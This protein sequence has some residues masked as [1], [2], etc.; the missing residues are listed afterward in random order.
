MNVADAASKATL[1]IV[2]D[3]PLN[4]KLL[5]FMLEEAQYDT[6]VAQSG[7]EALELLEEHEPDLALLDVMMPDIDGF[8]LCRRIKAIPR[9][10]G[11]PIIF[12]TAL[13]E[14]E[15]IVKGFE[16]G[17]VDYI[18]KPFN[19]KVL[20]VRIQNHIDLLNS[21]RQVERQAQDLAASNRLKDRMFSIISHD[22]RSPIGS[23]KMTLDYVLRGIIDPKQEGFTDTAR[24]MFYS[25]SEA[26]DLLE[27]LLGWAKSQSNKLVVTPEA[28]ELKELV[29]RVVRLNK[30]H[31][32]NKEICVH[33]EVPEGLRLWAD[34]HMVNSVLRNLLSNA[35]KFTPKGGRITIEATPLEE[36][37]QLSVS[38]T[39]VGIPPENLD[40]I[41][42][43]KSSLT[44][45]G[46]EKESG[47]GLGLL[48]C[49]N[50]VEKN[51][52]TI[53]VQS[54]VGEG[55]TFSFTLPSA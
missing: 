38:D 16:L 49:Q 53:D 37:V 33:T 32:E 41:F 44:T 4:V 15:D 48:L 20:L 19:K 1:L 55:T 13:H 9:H 10:A 17:G 46:T 18:T 8:E 11:M 23:V 29:E 31:T 5:K 12:I 47:S 45:E 51:G 34:M 25:I 50:F 3:S 24:E 7:P 39:G 14:T 36:E 26:L 30:L 22:L 54:K 43:N 28:I 21:K 40:K 52:G 2:D 42:D 27:N 6:L 35:L